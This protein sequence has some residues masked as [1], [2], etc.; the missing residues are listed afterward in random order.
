[1]LVE[2]FVTKDLQMT[3]PPKSVEILT[4]LAEELHVAFSPCKLDVQDTAAGL[5]KSIHPMGLLSIILSDT[6]WA[7]YPGNSSTDANGQ[8]VLA[9][10]YQVPAYVEINDTM[11][12]VQLYVAKASNDRLQA[13]IDAG[14]TLKRA[15]IQSL[16]RTVRQVIRDSKTRFQ[17]M[18]VSDIITRVN[19]QYGQMD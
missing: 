3:T 15:V 5:A 16:G 1:M 13:W 8:L 6:E 19:A 12:S 4:S 18:S 14:E 17:C 2:I 7:S 9:P 11:S 10:R